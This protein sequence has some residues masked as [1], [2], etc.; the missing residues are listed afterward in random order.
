MAD[1]PAGLDAEA[2]ATF[3]TSG[4]TGVPV[5]WIRSVGQLRAEASLVADAVTSAIDEIVCFAP[6]EHLFGRLF[7]VILPAL[8][9]VPVQLLHDDPARAP[10][11]R[12][13]RR[14]LFVCLPSSWLVLER[15]TGQIGLLGDTALLHGTG[16]ATDAAYRTVDALRGCQ[17]RAMEIFGSTETGGIAVRRLGQPAGERGD[18]EPWTLLPDVRL[19]RGEAEGTG[20]WMPLGVRSPRLA[21]RADQA[22]APDVIW[23]DDMIRPV[24][25]RA[26]QFIGRSSRLIKINGRR[27]DLGVIEQALSAALGTDTACVPV[28]DQVRGEH[29]ELFYAE[30]AA[31]TA[32]EDIWRRLAALSPGQPLPRA[33]HQVPAIPRTATG[34]V[35]LSRLRS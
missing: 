8:R 16:P 17:A 14:V 6:P 23:L 12:P 19:A 32:A 18:A 15:L 31:A 21:R 28:T 27:F 30:G 10:V 35:E 2:P 9:N 33:V 11:L 13:G 26:F 22:T 20:G 25:E 3:T 7:G 4:H 24:G 34:K 5:R 1:Q 29:Y